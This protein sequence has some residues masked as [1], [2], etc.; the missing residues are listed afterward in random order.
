MTLKRFDHTEIAL[1][2][3][4][5]DLKKENFE[6]L[7]KLFT[8]QTQEVEDAFLQ[9]ANQKNVDMASG[10]WLDFIGKMLGATRGG[11]SD[12]EYRRYLKIISLSS[13]ISGTPN[14][15]IST[16]R[17]YTAADFTRIV[18]HPLAH[19]KIFTSGSVNL[20][21][22]LTELLD[23]IKP[24]GTS[25]IVSA[26]ETDNAFRFA[27][28]IDTYTTTYAIMNAEA[29]ERLMEAGEALAEAGNSLLVAED[30]LVKVLDPTTLNGRNILPY[31]SSVQTFN[32]QCGETR[33]QCGESQ[34]QLGNT[35][36]PYLGYEFL[37]PL[38]WR[39]TESSAIR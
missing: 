33:L 11:R 18:E 39:V 27:W 16:I 36:N 28:A 8:T 32:V 10:V 17:Q 12:E 5:F 26:D 19:G 38:F 15:I 7:V 4:T 20:D 14:E 13:N 30:T 3:I 37:R 22:T 2:R 9:L 25:W 31:R 6:K 23:D 1:D 34:A 29:G 35:E 24:V 21:Y